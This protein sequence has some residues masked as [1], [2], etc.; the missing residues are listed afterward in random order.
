MVDGDVRPWPGR[1]WRTVQGISFQL[2]ALLSVAILPVG[3]VSVSQSL[4]LARE[5]RMSAEL[6]LQ[7]LTVKAASIDLRLITAGLAGV[8]QPDGIMRCTSEAVQQADKGFRDSRLFQR[9]VNNSGP[10]VDRL[11]IDPAQANWTL[12]ITQ[13]MV[14]N[15]VVTGFLSIALPQ[16]GLPLLIGVSDLPRPTDVMLFNQFGDTLTSIGPMDTAADRMPDAITL[17][18]QLVGPDRVLHGTSVAG[19][20]V[21]SAKVTLIDGMVDAVGERPLNNPI[22]RVDAVVFNAVL[23]PAHLWIASMS[24]AYLAA[25]RL[26]TFPSGLCAASLK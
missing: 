15:G 23:F 20:Q 14:E 12:V 26:A 9:L 18:A 21:T 10:W 2:I 22:T 8:T 3:A 25:N 17:N 7:S 4:S 6:L 16:L 1:L 19:K 24:V 11:K 5:S 13:P